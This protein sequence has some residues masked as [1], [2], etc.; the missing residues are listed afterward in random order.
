MTII[1]SDQLSAQTSELLKRVNSGEEILITENS[2]PIARLV[3]AQVSSQEQIHE[4][5]EALRALSQ[6]I[7]DRGYAAI[8]DEDVSSAIDEG[9]Y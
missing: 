6:Q 1:T 8:T 4:A 7:A 3:P 2:K 5:A 9:R